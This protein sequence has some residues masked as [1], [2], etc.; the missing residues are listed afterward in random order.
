[1]KNFTLVICLSLFMTSAIAGPPT[2]TVKTD[3]PSS[4]RFAATSFVIGDIGYVGTGCTGDTHTW[5]PSTNDFWAYNTITETWSQKASTTGGI[6]SAISFVINGKAY[7][8]C[9]FSA[10]D[11]WEYNPVTNMWRTL[12]PLPVTPFY[13]GVAFAINGKGYYRNGHDVAQSARTSFW[14]FDPAGNSGAGSWTQK[15]DLGTVSTGVVLRYSSGFAIGDYGYVGA[16]LDGNSVTRGEFYKYNPATDSW[17]DEASVDVR[18]HAVSFSD[19]S[20]GYIGLGYHTPTGLALSFFKFTPATTGLGRWDRL[21]LDYPIGQATPSGV[22][23][24]ATGFA[25]GTSLYIGTGESNF[26]GNKYN[27]F[28]KYS[29]SGEAVL[30]VELTNINAKADI[31]HEHVDV[32]WQT[33][34]ELQSAYFAIERQDKTT[35][36]FEEIGRINGAGNS[37]KT[38]NYTFID[39]KPVYGVSYYRL[40]LAD[41][42]GK[43]TYSK[44]VSVSYKGGAKVKVFPTF[45][46]GYITIDNGDKRIDDVYIWNASGQLML[47][48]KQTQ[49]DLSAFPR[50]LYLVQ[51]KTGGETFVQKITKK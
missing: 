35:H 3:F 20:S 11:F 22:R 32:N 49:L 31:P 25:V 45:T 24:L 4:A 33:A 27:D 46:E 13:Q 1:M 47:Q 40:R 23:S 36:Q 44:A 2:W 28:Y 30:P 26:G 8:G 41:I 21:P 18:S 17:S 10:P 37:S 16:G 14:M 15:T 42:D 29:P 9:G 7:V 48:S 6:N 50:G 43:T 39:E 12:T 38:L 51:V 34:T 5:Y 19:G